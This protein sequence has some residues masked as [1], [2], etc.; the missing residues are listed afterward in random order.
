M[1]LSPQPLK[2][3]LAALA[4]VSVSGTAIAQDAEKSAAPAQRPTPEQRLHNV[5]TTNPT[6]AAPTP[7]AFTPAAA[8]GERLP[9][10]RLLIT[11]NTPAQ[12]APSTPAAPSAGDIGTKPAPPSAPA[13][14]TPPRE[15][16]GPGGGFP[17]GGEGGGRRRAFGGPGGGFGGPGFGGGGAFGASAGTGAE[18]TFR[19]EGDQVMLMFSNNPVTDILSIYERL[20]DKTLVKDTNIFEGATI[21]LVTPKPVAKDE[22]I[23]LIEASLL[24]NGYAIVA[25]PGGKSAKILPTRGAGV[26]TMQFSAGVR[27]YTSPAELPTGETL[28]TYFMKLDFLDP[29]EASEILANHVG[30]NVYGRI[31]PV[32]TPPGLLITESATIVRQLIG[33]REAIDVGSTGSSLVTKFIPLKYADASVVAQIVQA[34]ISAQATER[35][36]KG[37]KTVRGE[38]QPSRGREGGDNN[39]RETSPRG[40]GEQP[41]QQQPVFYNGQWIYPPSGG[42]EGATPT[43]QVVADTRLN[44]VLV[45]ATPEDFT[46]ISSLIA[47]F[48]KPVVVD[49]PYERKLKYASAIDV[50]P[51]LADLIKDPAG[52]STQLPGG[53]AL[54][55]QANQTLVST[56]RSQILAGR[57]TTNARGGTVTSSLGSTGAAADGTTTGATSTG[58]GS[59]PDVIQGPTEDN[60]PLS[61]LVDK[62]RLI[63]DPMA[64]SIIVIGTK[65]DADKVD[66]LLDK[67]DRKPAQVYLATVIGQLTLG[68]G[69]EF[70]IDYLSNFNRGGSD[71]GIAASSIFS[72]EDII[73]NNNISDVR[74]NLITSAFGPTKSLN[75]YGQIGDSVEMFVTA[76]ESTNR[77]K[78]LSR[79]SIFALNNKKA[80]ITSGRQIPVPSQSVTTAGNVN[81]AGTVTTTVE[82]RD[83]VLKL[84][85]VPLINADGEVNLTIAQVNDT[86]IGSQR[87][88]PN[89]VPIIGTEQLITSVNVPTGN[90]V[91]L[92]G[93]ISEEKKKDTAGMPWVSRVP[94]LG[95]LFKDTSDS[96]TR[97]ELIVFIQPVVVTDNQSL[98]TAS[99]NEDIRTKIGESA[100]KKF[101]QVPEPPKMK[102]MEEKKPNFFKRLFSR[103]Q[104]NPLAP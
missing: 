56:S 2:R 33:I 90:T 81:T 92:G 89:D 100:A 71:A 101:P 88:E 13:G 104:K 58:I 66:G 85:V 40:T 51:S 31:T 50:L 45:V 5:Q 76:L 84:E 47:E 28:V 12:P 14:G 95:N 3:W 46:Y 99:Y 22:A 11:Q 7:P 1:H 53:G 83:V 21:S 43:S 49:E 6:P 20:T 75:I 79:P 30:L 60:A 52:G 82:Y 24:T 64:N 16:G 36:T 55:T 15:P 87:V 103:P 73:T 74:D 98:K 54:S 93:L 68:D 70:G 37:V 77:F 91:V 25:E 80:T 78:V 97:K 39:N 44:Q 62:T 4:T 32:L 67:L 41:R 96:N 57:T 86:V 26:T 72:R 23:R 42:S 8:P 10:E 65:E 29:T 48:D 59:R 63:A 19:I 35:E 17:G 9:E 38:A 34:T 94:L 27:F 69:F 102:P 18:E 61:I